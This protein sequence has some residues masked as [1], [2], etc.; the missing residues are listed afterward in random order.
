[1]FTGFFLVLWNFLGTYDARYDFV[2]NKS[3]VFSMASRF[4]MPNDSLMKPGPGAHRPE[5]LNL[6]LTPSFSFGKR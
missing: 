5:R 1:M 6:G 3:P 4:N 2:K